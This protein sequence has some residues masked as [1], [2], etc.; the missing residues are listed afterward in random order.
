MSEGTRVFHE[1][2]DNTVEAIVRTRCTGVFMFK[3]LLYCCVSDIVV[4]L[5]TKYIVSFGL[6]LPTQLQDYVANK[7]F[8]KPMS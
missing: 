5:V 2:S 3:F 7:L 4:T 8:S 6:V 1:G